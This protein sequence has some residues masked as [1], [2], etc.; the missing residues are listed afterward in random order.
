MKRHWYTIKFEYVKG[1]K[2]LFQT[3]MRVSVIDQ[4]DILYNRRIKCAVCRSFIQNQ[5]TKHLLCNGTITVSVIAYL[6][7][8]ASDKIT[9]RGCFEKVFGKLLLSYFIAGHGHSSR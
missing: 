2:S 8:F 4:S 6:G 7:R 5:E 3:T 9:L 1:A